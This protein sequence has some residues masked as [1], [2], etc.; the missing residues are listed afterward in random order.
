VE[1]KEQHIKFIAECIAK[2]LFFVEREDNSPLVSI[3]GGIVENE[4]HN[5]ENN[6]IDCENPKEDIKTAKEILAIMKN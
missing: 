2:E 1:F 4:L 5:I 3:V 6:L